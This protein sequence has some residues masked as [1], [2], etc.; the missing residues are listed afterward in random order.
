MSKFHDQ[1]I[2]EI[3]N[4]AERLVSTARQQRDSADD[5]YRRYD[6]DPDKVRAVLEAHGGPGQRE[7]ARALVRADLK[8]IELE[9]A[10]EKARRGFTQARRKLKR[11]RD[12]I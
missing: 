9:M 5:L 7:K 3:V 10:E 4:Q 2:T 12:M 8:E 1:K 6:L 11:P